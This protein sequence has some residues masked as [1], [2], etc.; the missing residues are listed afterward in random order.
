MRQLTSG[1]EDHKLT[2][3]FRCPKL[4]VQRQQRHAPGFRAAEG[5][6]QGH[7]QRLGGRGEDEPIPWYWQDLMSLKPTS[8]SQVAILCRNNAP[9]FKLAFRLLRRQT[10][11]I[12]AGRDIGKGLISLARK[13]S[14]DDPSMSA[15]RLTI[16]IEAW[17]EREH[18]IAMAKGK[19]AQADSIQ[20][21][22][23]CLHAVLEGTEAKDAGQ[24]VH[25]L[26]VLF[27]RESAPILLS[28]IHKAKGLEW[29]LVVHLD[30]WR[31]PSRAA[32][33]AAMAGKPEALE[34]EWNLAYV[35]ETRTR[36]VL[37]EADLEGLKWR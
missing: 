35:A 1:W 12:M 10:P 29:D 33:I 5:N 30:P 2:L 4:I 15:E 32:K 16:A 7:Y 17:R 14:N 19:E 25:Q 20:D 8:S 22:A 37:V 3:T 21:R 9:L 28:S 18:A 36:S 34:Q 6:A 24:L 26:E 23:E 31:I 27:S 11:V 13:L